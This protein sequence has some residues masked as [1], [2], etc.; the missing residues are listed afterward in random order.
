MG[1]KSGIPDFVVCADGNFFTVEAKA[2]G[3]KPTPL[4]NKT[5]HDITVAGG[6]A[7]LVRGEHEAALVESYLLMFGCTYKDATTTQ[8]SSCHTRP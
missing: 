6:A 7:L 2:I 3:G 4:Q 1:G 5:A 8:Q